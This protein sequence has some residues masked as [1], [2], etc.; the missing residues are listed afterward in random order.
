MLYFPPNCQITNTGTNLESDSKPAVSAPVPITSSASLFYS[1]PEVSLW[2]TAS[3]PDSVLSDLMF[4][5]CNNK[6][7]PQKLPGQKSLPEPNLL[8]PP[9]AIIQNSTSPAVKYNLM[10]SSTVSKNRKRSSTTTS[11]GDEADKD[12]E[13]SN[14][15]G[16][17]HKITNAAMKAL[18]SDGI[19]LAM[20]FANG[21]VPLPAFTDNALPVKI[22]VANS[23]SS[24]P[25]SMKRKKNPADMDDDERILASDEAK[26]LTSRQRRQLR[27]RVSARHFRLR[28]KEYIN[29]LEALVINMTSKINKISS[30][31]EDSKQSDRLLALIGAQYPAILRQAQVQIQI[32]PEMVQEPLVEQQKQLQNLQNQHS[33]AGS[34]ACQHIPCSSAPSIAFSNKPESETVSANNTASLPNNNDV[35]SLSNQSFISDFLSSKNISSSAV[36]S[37]SLSSLSSSSSYQAVNAGHDLLGWDNKQEQDT[38]TTQIQPVTIMDSIRMKPNIVNLLPSLS[39]KPISPPSSSSPSSSTSSDAAHRSFKNELQNENFDLSVL[40]YNFQWNEELDPNSTL[41]A[42]HNPT[43]FIQLPNQRIYRSVVPDLEKQLENMEIVRTNAYEK[44]PE[45]KDSKTVY[46][47]NH[48]D[49]KPATGPEQTNPCDPKPK[50]DHRS[51]SPSAIEKG[52]IESPAFQ[53]TKEEQ[54]AYHK[55]SMVTAEAIFG[56]LDLQM[57]SIQI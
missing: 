4:D 2:D 46:K 29:H 39:S 52:K 55:L 34:G 30:Q 57:A 49:M 10:S 37:S 27:N 47:D 21:A 40:K 18:G 22:S 50:E 1:S 24:I 8:N 23:N 48:V 31:S 41:M 32:T 53:D 56:R 11:S 26:K 38:Q 14:D 12:E 44:E 13:L 9:N 36:S 54:L 35:Y 43:G 5:Q 3:S 25:N 42:P 51:L 19:D 16:Y 28:R 45:L 20:Q 7:Q 17:N 15:Y 6:A 33:N